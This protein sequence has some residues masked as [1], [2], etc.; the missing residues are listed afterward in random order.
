M[1]YQEVAKPKKIEKGQLRVWHIPQ[2]P[3]HPFKVYVSSV[4]EAKK[5]LDVLAIYDLFQFKYKIKPDYSNI[6]GLEIYENGEW[7]DW[8]NEVGDD[9]Y[10]TEEVPFSE[11]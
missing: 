7:I 2:V 8:E 4:K 9:I 5:I 3:M 11:N 1:L 6:S 10:N